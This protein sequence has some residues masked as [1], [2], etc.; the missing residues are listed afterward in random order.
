VGKAGGRRRRATASR[1]S[2]APPRRKLPLPRR[3]LSLPRRKLPPPRRKLSLPRRKLALPRRKL[4]S[5]RR[6]LSLPRR[7]LS[8]PRRKLSLPRRK[9]A[10]P[11]RKLPLPRRKLPLPRSPRAALR[12]SRLPSRVTAC[13]GCD[14]RRPLQSGA[15]RGLRKAPARVDVSGMSWLPSLARVRR[16]GRSVGR[17][18]P[19]E[20]RPPITGTES[21]C[22]NGVKPLGENGLEKWRGE[23]ESGPI[24]ISNIKSHKYPIPKGRRGG[25]LVTALDIGYWRDWIL[26]IDVVVSADNPCEPDG[27]PMSYY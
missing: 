11:R 25:L 7:K 12:S 15:V 2:V 3:K 19:P 23:A 10:P 20:T 6:K 4:A 14:T 5:P 9:L 24:S 18:A 21:G 13:V 8:L 1:R 27:L 17:Q 22:K 16:V 26:D